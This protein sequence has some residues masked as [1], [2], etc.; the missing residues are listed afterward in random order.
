MKQKRKSLTT[1]HSEENGLKK[2]SIFKQW[3]FGQK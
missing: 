3:K 2:Y 1:F